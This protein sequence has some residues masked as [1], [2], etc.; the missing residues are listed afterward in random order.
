ME[1]VTQKF[2]ISCVK[3]IAIGNFLY[4]S[5]NSNRASVAGCRVGGEGDAREVWEGR[6]MDVPM[7]DSY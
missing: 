3:Q 7:A 5:G 2:T 1:S 4:D 6:D